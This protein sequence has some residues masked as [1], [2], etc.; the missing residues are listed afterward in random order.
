MIKNYYILYIF[1][2]NIILIKNKNFYKIFYT[3]FN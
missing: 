2:K 1:Y 3:F